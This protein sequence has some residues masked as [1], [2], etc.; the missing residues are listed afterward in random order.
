M[1]S[2][3]RLSIYHHGSRDIYPV[4]HRG[5]GGTSS[6]HVSRMLSREEDNKMEMAQCINDIIKKSHK[7]INN[8][9][10]KSRFH[11]SSKNLKKEEC[12]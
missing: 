6:L 10:S 3:N 9:L 2:Q 4:I 11:Q 5:H 8:A 7:K 1:S 12:A